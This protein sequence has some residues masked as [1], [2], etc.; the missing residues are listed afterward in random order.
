MIKKD[1]TKTYKVLL[2][3]FLFIGLLNSSFAQS[4]QITG[5]ITDEMKNPLPGVSIIVKGTT[6]GT[7]TDAD[8][9]YTLHVPDNNAIL[10]FSFIGYNTEEIPV[11]GKSTISLNLQPDIQT[12]SEVIVVGYGTQKKSDVTGAITSVNEKTFKDMPVSN[13]GLALRGLGAGIDIQRSGGNTHPAAAPTI[14]IRGD[15]SISAGNSPLMIVDGIPYDGNLNDISVEDIASVQVL[16]DASSTAIYGSRGANGVILISTKRGKDQAPVFTYNAFSGFNRALGTYDM[17]NAQQFIMFKKY[18]RYYGSPTGTYTGVDDP[19]L[20]SDIFSGDEDHRAGYLAGID[21]DWQDHVY[22]KGRMMSHQLGFSGGTDKT[23]YAVSAGYYGEEGNYALNDF[24]RLTLKVSLEQ[25]I[26]SYLKLGISSLNTYARASGLDSSP[27]DAALQA[28]PMASPYKSDGTLWRPLPGGNQLVYNPLLDLRDGAVVDDQQ[29]LSTFT[30]GYLDVDLTHGFK[31]KLNAGV[32]IDPETRGKFY[33]RESTKQSGRLSYAYNGNSSGYNYTLE[34]ILTYDKTIANVHTINFTGL[35]SLQERQSSWTHVHGEGLIDDNVQYY[36][37][38][39]ASANLRANGSYEKWDMVSYMGR[40]NYNYDERYLLT[41]TLRADGSSRLAPGNKWFTFP[42]AAVAWNISNEDFM[43]SNLIDDLKLRASYGTVGNT[44][45]AAYSTMGSLTLA[46]YNFGTTT[47]NGVFPA[48]IPNP[49]LTWE[50][51]ATLNIGL[52]FGIWNSRISGAVEYYHQN[53]SS[54]L[55]NQNL[56]PTSGTTSSFKTNVGK[57]ENKGLE[58]TINTVNINGDGDK[59]LRWTTDF[60]VFFNRNKI[61][62]LTSGVKQDYGSG[63]FVGEPLGT[64]YDYQRLGIWQNTAADSALAKS[65]GLQ[66]TGTGSVIGTVKVA[67]IAI[68]YDAEGNPLPNQRINADDRTIIGNRQPDFEGGISNRLSYRNF[69]FSVVAGFRVGGL[70]YSDMYGG[71]MNTFQGGYNNIDVEYWTEENPTNYWPKPNSSQ[72]NPAYKSTLNY[73]DASYLKIR[74]ITVG[75]SL[76]AS[77]VG[78]IGIKS[79]RIYTTA[80]NPFVFFSD[81]VDK[82]NGVDPEAAGNMGLYAAAPWSMVF[83]FNVSF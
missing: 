80:S 81:Y 58:V 60:N 1:M 40:L 73:F 28:S 6:N 15:R 69:D 83:G 68:D 76:P 2:F 41:A 7:S 47:E 8:G 56:P 16:K 21:T 70:L 67:N 37:P 42:S 53:T 65:Y 20:E 34:N 27:M 45:I 64:I 36:N 14:R 35:Y 39:F 9:V 11:E 30:T 3:C 5:V 66:T 77:V 72:Q 59:S 13:I 32:Q 51:T 57:T 74:M 18:A 38:E 54:L 61:I 71:W 63:W 79:A 44:A 62:A 82:F 23:T 43:R 10:I 52:D 26:T 17:M 29:R 50:N 78:R 31:Y 33:S 75:Y 48:E 24:K 46:K 25:K 49:T 19:K 55:L 22:Q 4:Q 12:L